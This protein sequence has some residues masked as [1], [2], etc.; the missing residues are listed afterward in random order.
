V[1]RVDPLCVDHRAI[2]KEEPEGDHRIPVCEGTRVDIT[3]TDT[4]VTANSS[5]ISCAGSECVVMT[6]GATE[7]YMARSS[8]GMDTD[9]ITII[10]K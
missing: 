1:D 10:P 5:G 8:D 6:I 4:T 9:R 7:K 2:Y 3:V